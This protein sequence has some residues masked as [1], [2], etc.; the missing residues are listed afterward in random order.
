LLHE[1]YPDAKEP[2][3]AKTPSTEHVSIREPG[4]DDAQDAPLLDDADVDAPF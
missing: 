3:P 2:T 4:E 1:L